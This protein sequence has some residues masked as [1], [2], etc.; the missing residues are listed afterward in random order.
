MRRG[1]DDVPRAVSG[2]VSDPA[3]LIFIGDVVQHGRAAGA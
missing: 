1:D 2:G 3:V